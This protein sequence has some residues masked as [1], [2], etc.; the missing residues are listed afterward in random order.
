MSADYNEVKTLHLVT[1]DDYAVVVGVIVVVVEQCDQIGRFCVI[2]V[3]LG[4]S[5]YFFKGQKAQ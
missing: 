4:T 2:W 3:L 5:G 1:L